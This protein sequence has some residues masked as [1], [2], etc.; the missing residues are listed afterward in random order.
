MCATRRRGWHRTSAFSSALTADTSEN[1]AVG[2]SR[3]GFGPRRQDLH[4]GDRVV[5]RASPYNGARGT[6]LRTTRVLGKPAWVVEIGGR[7]LF[8]WFGRVRVA[9]A[10]LDR[11]ADTGESSA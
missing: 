10:F 5:I 1:G 8:A 3:T 6:L 4:E 7:H 2:I 9:D 11:L